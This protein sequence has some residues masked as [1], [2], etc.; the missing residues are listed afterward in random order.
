[1]PRLQCAP[2]PSLVSR[3]ASDLLQS[4]KKASEVSNSQVK[5]GVDRAKPGSKQLEVFFF[6]GGGA[7]VCR[8]VWERGSAAPRKDLKGKKFSQKV[9]DQKILSLSSN[10]I[11]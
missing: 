1:M 10:N 2:P 5:R 6:G 8:K 4:Q 9:T 3:D 11:M 7:A